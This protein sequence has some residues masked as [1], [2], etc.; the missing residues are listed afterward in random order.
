MFDWNDTVT[1]SWGGGGEENQLE[2]MKHFNETSFNN[3][4]VQL[5]GG[6]AEIEIARHNS[7]YLVL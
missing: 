4:D 2:L 3:I 7:I 5:T 1:R 6:A